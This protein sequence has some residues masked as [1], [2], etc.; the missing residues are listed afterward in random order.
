M[1]QKALIGVV[2]STPNP[3]TTDVIGMD[4]T[5]MVEVSSEDLEPY[6]FTVAEV[7]FYGG[8]FSGGEPDALFASWRR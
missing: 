5:H 8:V 1:Q 6:A 4:A 2:M 3:R 7:T